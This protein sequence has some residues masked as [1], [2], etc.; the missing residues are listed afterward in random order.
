LL[1]FV[2][3]GLKLEIPAFTPR[4]AGIKGMHHHIWAQNSAFLRKVTY[5]ICTLLDNEYSPTVSYP[6]ETKTHSKSSMLNKIF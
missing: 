5:S 1:T 6:R 3:A 4:V 2:Q